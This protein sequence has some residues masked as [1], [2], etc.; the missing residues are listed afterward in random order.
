ML[1]PGFAHIPVRDLPVW[2]KVFKKEGITS[3][4]EI[5]K[6][7]TLIDDLLALQKS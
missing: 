1:T 2:I 7:L 6:E 5:Q 4:E 3:A